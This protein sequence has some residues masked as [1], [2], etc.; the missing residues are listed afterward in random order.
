MIEK[1]TYGLINQKRVSKESKQEVILNYS[2]IRKAL[3]KNILKILQ[4]GDGFFSS[5]TQYDET[6]E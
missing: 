6:S 3:E 5:Y 1:I 2:A 4:I